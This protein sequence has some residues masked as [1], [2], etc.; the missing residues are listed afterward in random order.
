MNENRFTSWGKR[1]K[2]NGILLNINFETKTDSKLCCKLL[3][4]MDREYDEVNERLSDVFNWYTE[5]YGKT[6]LDE[7]LEF[8]SDCEKKLIDLKDTL[9]YRS[10]QL[11]F[12]EHLIDDLGCEEMRRQWEEFNKL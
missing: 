10:E 8:K 4:Q 7:R 2:R 5:H 9:A 1:I 6:I 11:S 12:A 3:N